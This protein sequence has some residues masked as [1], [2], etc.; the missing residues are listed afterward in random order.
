MN[1][2]AIFAVLLG[3]SAVCYFLLGV[4]LSSGDREIGSRPLGAAMLIIACWVMGG[5][6]EIM[7]TSFSAFTVGRVGHYLGTALVPV[8]ILLCFREFTGRVTSRRTVIELMVIPVLSI[9]LA[10]TNYWHEFMW[11]LPAT[12][13][14]GEFLTRPVEFGPWFRYVHLPYGYAVIG[15]SVLTLIMHSSAVAP[16]QRRG[17]FLLGGSAMVPI[18]AVV[19]Y[20]MGVGPSTIS[21]LPFI[22]ALMLPIYAWLILGERIIEYSPLAYE[23]VFQHMQ[24]PVIVIDNEERIIGLNQGAERLLNMG[25][26]DALKKTLDKVFGDEAMEVHIAL[27]TGE[28]QKMLTH[29]GRFLH[30]QVTPISAS[31]AASRNANVLMFRD[32]SDVEKAQREV[33]NSEKLLRTL[34]DHSV[35]GVI[36]FRWTIDDVPGATKELRCTFANAAAGR[37]LDE[38]AESM[39]GRD[40]S[41][42]LQLAMTGMADDEAIALRQRFISAAESGEVVD[43]EVSVE[44]RTDARW[45]RIISEPVGE[46]VAMTFV[47]V[48]DRK[49]K[50]EQ[51]ETIARSDPLTGVLNR[52]GFE[53]DA[54]RR[55][56]QSADDATGAL[57]FID[58]N[59]FKMVNDKHGHEIGDR[60][61]KIAAERLQQ[62]LRGGDII[63][64]PGGDEFVALVPDVGPDVAEKLATRLTRTLEQPYRINGT[65]LDCAASIGLAL[66]PEHANTLTGLLR[67][68]DAA[69]YRAKARCRNGRD[70]SDTDLLEIAV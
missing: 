63:G 8:F 2:M 12:N 17:L 48:T 34:I 55:L 26:S 42:L 14:A 60:L 19:A 20:D 36:R 22:F 59:D 65:E 3:F 67:A 50:E 32:V 16:S 43:T 6:I 18:I 11:Y 9:I 61:L 53:R 64:R 41:E 13:A 37:Y 23:T 62:S 47:D 39:V 69:M 1:L 40:A 7:A 54:A 15:T 27:D 25:E 30:V 56:T 68:A 4:R 58:L 49:V 57:L 5:A 35:N 51:M 66:Y 29:S 24:D 31:K 33:Q 44:T 21:T 45:L 38:D 46:D 28:P 10:A 70:I 52:R